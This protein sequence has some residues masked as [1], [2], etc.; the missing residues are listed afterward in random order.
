MTIDIGRRQ[1]I[2]ALGGAAVAWPLAA[3][4]QRATMP[5]IGFLHIGAPFVY[6]LA[7]LRQGLKEVGYIEGENVAI[8][9]RWANND[10]DQLAVL[11]ADLVHRR[12]DVIVALAS[13]PVAIAA[14]AATT[15]IPIVFGYGGDPVRGGLVTSLNRPGGNITGVSSLSGELG[16]KQIGLLHQLLPHAVRFAILVKPGNPV[17]ETLIR[18]AKAAASAIG[19]QIEVFA[20]STNA[21]ID[22]AFASLVQKQTEA[23]L[24]TTDPFFGDRRSQLVTLTG[25]HILPSI[26]PFRDYAEAGG[27]M[28]YGPNLKD[29]DHRVGLYVGRIL[30]GEKPADLP[31]EQSSKF[32][33][34]I[35]A[36]TAKALGIDVPP[37]LL[38]I[39]DEVIE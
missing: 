15:T 4:A 7:G 5:V 20:V 34:V 19:G 13:G 28:T 25:R 12:V 36:E 8:E 16:G 37:T 2:S 21:E 23:L 3:S 1:F 6:A 10:A 14:K 31:V 17:N 39:A 24:I 9:Y 29:R 11:A 26:Y 35:N 32:E 27:L 38:V 22:I 33:L 18:D 30:N